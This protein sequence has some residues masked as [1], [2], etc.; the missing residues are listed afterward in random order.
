MLALVPLGEFI[1]EINFIRYNTAFKEIIIVC[2]KEYKNNIFYFKYS[3][4]GKNLKAL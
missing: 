3:T 2:Y 1:K 4:S